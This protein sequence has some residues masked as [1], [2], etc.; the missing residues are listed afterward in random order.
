MIPMVGCPGR[1]AETASHPERL[2]FD[3]RNPPSKC[4]LVFKP[5]DIVDYSAETR[6]GLV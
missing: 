3:N 2:G 6:S 4:I 1:Q 5:I